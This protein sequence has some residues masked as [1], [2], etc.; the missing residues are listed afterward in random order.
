MDFVI[1]RL[2]QRS[3]CG[4]AAFFHVVNKLGETVATGY[5][6]RGVRIA[7]DQDVVLRIRHRESAGA[8]MTIGEVAQEKD[9]YEIYSEING[10][11]FGFNKEAL[12]R[13]K[14]LGLVK[15][16]G[17][18]LEIKGGVVPPLPGARQRSSAET[19]KIRAEL[20]LM[21]RGSD[22]PL[23]FYRAPYSLGYRDEG[24]DLT[25]EFLRKAALSGLITHLKRLDYPYAVP[26]AET[27][28]S[29]PIIWTS[30]LTWLRGG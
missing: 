13:Y 28:P 6:R 15:V 18:L 23:W 11:A 21:Q 26:K 27:L 19:T 25:A 20:R 16:D 9:A 30:E 29:L 24:Q 17:P 5:A 10:P 3:F 7:K 22:R 8:T 12:E 1:E 4:R 14:Q 2:S